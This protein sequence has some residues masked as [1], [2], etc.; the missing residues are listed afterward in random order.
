MTIIIIIIA[1]CLIAFYYPV[2]QIADSFFCILY[3]AV[4]FL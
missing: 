3:S 4:D 2:F 1:L